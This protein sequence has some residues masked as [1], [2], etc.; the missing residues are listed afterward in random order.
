MKVTYDNI[1][2]PVVDIQEAVA[3]AKADGTFDKQHTG[4][5]SNKPLPDR[6]VVH[7]IKGSMEI[8]SQHHFY[9]EPQAVVCHPR[10]DGIDV[11]CPTQASRLI[12]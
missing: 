2:K 5:F 4:K 11:Y 1:K 6:S 10:E 9:M 12:L 8:G 7:T 3:K